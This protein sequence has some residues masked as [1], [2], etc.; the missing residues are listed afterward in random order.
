MSKSHSRTQILL[1]ETLV[2]YVNVEVFLMVTE[3]N[4]TISKV[5]GTDNDKINPNVSDGNNEA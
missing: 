5:Q 2:R 4:V 1:N 3:K